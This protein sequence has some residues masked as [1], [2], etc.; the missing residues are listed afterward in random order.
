MKPIGWPRYMLEKPLKSGGTAYYWNPPNRDIA[1][2]F[3][4]PREALGA[5]YGPAVERAQVL[6]THLDAWRNGRGAVKIDETQPGYA[7]LGWLFDQYRRHFQKRVSERAQPGYERALRTIEDM[8][9]KLGEP[10]ARL[11]LSSI[12]PAAAD[13]F[14][15]RLL[16]GP[17]KAGRA[18]V[19]NY[20]IDIARRAWNVVQRKHPKVV[21]EGN[22]WTMVERVRKKKRIKPAAT[23]VEAF[24][25]AAA[26]KEIG[27]PHLGAA[28]LICFEWHQRPENVLAGL[29][30]W[31]DYSPPDH[32]LIRHGKT[33][34]AVPLPLRDELGSFYPEIE[35]FLAE[36]PKLGLPIVLTTGRRGPARPYSVEYA[37][38]RVR[39]A[40]KHAGLGEH[41][42]LD[43]CRHGGLTE[44]ADAGAT[45]QQMRA[46]SGHKTDAAL[47]VYLKQTAVQ[48]ITAS[49]Q[50]RDHVDGNKQGAVVRIGRQKR[51]QNGTADAS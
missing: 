18:T 41:V 24:A 50:R 8:P 10:A 22:P 20:C 48:R 21:R 42:T 47:R 19:A 7:T 16:Q 45:E 17:R 3:T 27:E 49:R 38:R 15:E 44:E 35:A 33:D 2:G 29:I 26:L 32:V 28:A 23:R 30:T 13:K 37:Q 25:L 40:R 12:T 31:T 1:A 34:E 11:P 43:A 14:Y 46:K 4:L 6:N 36:L 9:T 51:R 5:D 39:E